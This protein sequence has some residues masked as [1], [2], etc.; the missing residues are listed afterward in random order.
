MSKSA[1]TMA[2]VIE[3]MDAP[4]VNAKKVKSAMTDTERE[5]KFDEKNKPGISNLLTIYSALTGESIKQLEENYSGKGYGDLKKELADVVVGVL[6]PIRN[7][8]LDYLKDPAQLQ[9]I[10]KDGGQ[11]AG[12]V[13]AQTLRNVYSAMGLVA[14]G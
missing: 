3:L 14:R 8:A 11:R 9:S 4:E 10:L 12:S 6:E 13:A 2:G 7:S 1:A 5:I